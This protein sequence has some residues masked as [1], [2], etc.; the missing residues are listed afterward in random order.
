MRFQNQKSSP[1]KYKKDP[2]ENRKQNGPRR[3]KRSLPSLSPSFEQAFSFDKTAVAWLGH[4]SVFLHIN[5][6]DILI[7][8]VFSRCLSPVGVIGPRRFPGKIPK[9]SDFPLLDAVLITHNHYDHLDIPTICALDDQTACYIVPKGIGKTLIGHNIA[10]EKI[11]ELIWFEEINFSG[12]RIICTPAQHN[13][14]RGL[15]DRDKSLWCSFVLQANSNT[16]FI[17]GDTGFSN[18]FQEIHDAFGDMDLA[19]MECGQYGEHWHHLHMFPEEA[20]EACEILHA[21]LAIPVH[22]GAYVLSTHPWKEP[23]RRFE[24]R[25]I[26]RDVNYIIP[27]I[28]QIYSV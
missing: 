28:N 17:S 5:G 4:S 12:L 2:F 19:I 7:D 14:Q 15:W 27:V 1:D 26:E 9:P 16:V 21:K 20:V 13:S 3:P 6:L 22:W 11:H 10:P 23:P 25:A 24:K 18:H 8:P